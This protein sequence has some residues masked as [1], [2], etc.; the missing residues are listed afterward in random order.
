M[1]TLTALALVAP[2]MAAAPDNDDIADALALVEGVER[3]A[4]LTDATT[5]VGEDLCEDGPTA[6]WSFTAPA[7]GDYVSYATGANFDTAV[8]WSADLTTTS[9][10]CPDDASDS[11]DAIEAALSLA[12][13]EQ[14]YVQLGPYAGES[15]GSGGVGVARLHAADDAFADRSALTFRAGAPSAVRGVDLT[16]TETVEAGEPVACGTEAFNGSAW[17]S[18]TP[19]TTGAWMIE[20]KS[21]TEVDLAIYTG[22]SLASLDL[23]ACTVG[24]R[25]AL[26][27]ELE[28]GT[29]YAIQLHADNN[30]PAVV[31]AEYAGR[32]RG[33]AQL[34]S[35]DGVV[36]VTSS[37]ALVDG[38]P[39]IAFYDSD[40]DELR[41]A[42]RSAD[43]VWSD[44]LVDADGGGTSTNVGREIDMVV[45]ADGRPAI[46]FYDSDDDELRYAERSA[47]GVWSDVLVD[48]DGDGTSTNVGY[49]LAMIVLANGEPAIA[50]QD[51][52]ERSLRY[53]ERSGGVWSDVLVDDDGDG[54]STNV[55]DDLA[56]ALYDGE[57]AIAYSDSTNSEKRLATRS[58][59]TWSESLILG[60]ETLPEGDVTNGADSQ[61]DLVV[62]PD[63][64][65]AIV[66]QDNE[67][68][69]THYGVMTGATW[70]MQHIL[71][72]RLLAE[73]GWEGTVKLDYDGAGD[74]VV[75]W[76]DDNSSYQ[77]GVSTWRDGEWVEEIGVPHL[78][79]PKDHDGVIDHSAADFDTL[80]MPDGRIGRTAY[81]A[82]T[83]SLWWVEDRFRVCPDDATPF[84]D[85]DPGSFAKDDIPCIYGLAVTTGTS[86][87]EYSPDDF[88]TRE[89]M[90]AF[91]ARLYRKLTGEE[92][93]G[94]AHPFTDID[95]GSFAKDDIPCIFGLG[96]T[97]GTSPTLYSPDDF[98]TR[99]QMAAF[100]ARLYRLVTDA[101]CSGGAHPFTDIDAGSFAKDD[102]PCIFGVG[103]TTGTSPT[104]YSPDDF[105]TR[106]QMAAF[107][108]RFWRTEAGT[109]S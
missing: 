47:D 104:L 45:L 26:G 65:L 12:N 69:H 5:E 36:G 79:D 2:V 10:V 70:D 108:A 95:A 68:G 28:A 46:A 109:P 81:D 75:H 20:V 14:E 84:T 51:R 33:M 11:Y 57:P 72:N 9:G 34:V 107:M 60:P 40:D 101:G 100:V 13:G 83:D 31:R 62:R 85:V 43:G 78:S 7:A 25:N 82:E 38:H 6:W 97:T 63:G 73:I 1:V 105:V 35:D 93:S 74:P 16:G 49:D 102:I 77:V 99:E 30:K 98:V 29:S 17:M 48:A 44:V 37:V 52:T 39:A 80:L 55:G 4:D 89:Q 86:P 76:Q 56:M 92:C 87:A 96:M 103:I 66:I 61:P 94:G 21:R 54:T 64:K 90:A 3:W 50:Y 41:Y 27:I 58:A 18:F 91:M 71:S 15:R 42:E 106:E 19:P 59:G 8:G 22:T 53:A 23:L 32:M 67:I 88:V 24:Y